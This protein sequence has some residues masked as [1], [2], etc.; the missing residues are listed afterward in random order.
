MILI[1]SF[2]DEIKVHGRKFYGVFWRLVY[3]VPFHRYIPD[4]ISEDSTQ[5]IEMNE[6]KRAKLTKT[7]IVFVK[8][9][10]FPKQG[11]RLEILQPGRW[12]KLRGALTI[13]SKPGTTFFNSNS[14]ISLTCS[15][16]D[17]R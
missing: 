3:Q 4:N 14:W 11:S 17:S 8:S 2:C 12:N 10:Q 15:K 7:D 5:I 1:F 16:Y 6:F 9:F 13:S